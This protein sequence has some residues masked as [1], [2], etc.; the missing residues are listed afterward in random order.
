MRI[1]DAAAAAGMTARALRYYEE[2]GLVIAR[3][4][5][6]GHRVYEPED[7]RKL[8]TV[9]ELLDAGLTVGDIR[10][11]APLLDALPPE[12]IPELFFTQGGAQSGARGGGGGGPAG[13]VADLG[14]T[15]HRR[16]A[17]EVA[18]RRL[19]DLDARIERLTRLRGR[20]ARRLG[21]P[22]REPGRVA[23]YERALRE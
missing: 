5:P 21:E 22:A 10:S 2:H 8:R 7:V 13:D 23:P 20:L 9:R 18:R 16:T 17:A 1:G 4:T 3:R 11:F 14:P 12:G 19:A 15:Q 6:S